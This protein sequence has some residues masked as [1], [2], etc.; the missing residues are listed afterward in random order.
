MPAQLKLHKSNLQE[1]KDLHA[2]PRRLPEAS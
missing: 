1:S 2:L